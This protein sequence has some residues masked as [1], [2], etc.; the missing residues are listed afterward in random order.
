MWNFTPVQP[1]VFLKAHLCLRLWRRSVQNVECLRWLCLD[2]DGVYGAPRFYM[3]A[4]QHK[5][6]AH[7]GAEISLAGA[8]NLPVLV[9][10]RV[11]YQNLCRLIT[12][13]K[14]RSEKKTIATSSFEEIAKPRN[15]LI[16]LTGDERGVLARAMATNGVDGG[17][18]CA[19]R[20]HRCL[21][22]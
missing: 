11:G 1:L 5:I 17:Q 14:L 8:G 15:G 7:V 10:S 2:R 3:A 21:W 19:A 16:C 4:R 18:A 22:P 12:T 9:A 20:T 6:K 13:A